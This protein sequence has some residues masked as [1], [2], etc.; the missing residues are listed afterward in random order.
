MFTILSTVCI[1]WFGTKLER[2]KSKNEVLTLQLIYLQNILESEL[3]SQYD[4]LSHLKM[5][6]TCIVLLNVLGRKGALFYIGFWIKKGKE[7]D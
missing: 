2:G 6:K 3:K 4:C 5:N 7:C 1:D